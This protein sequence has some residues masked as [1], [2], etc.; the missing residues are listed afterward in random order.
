M[1]RTGSSYR[2]VLLS[3][4]AAC[5]V[6]GIVA[7]LISRPWIT[8]DGVQ[9]LALANSI[10]EGRYGYA[11]PTGFESD[12]LRPPGYPLLLALL[13]HGLRVPLVVV[14]AMQAAAYLASIYL[15]QRFLQQRKINPLPF[16]AIA[17]MYPFV[18]MY[19]ARTMAEGWTILAVT[20]VTV[21]LGNRRGSWSRSAAIGL[22]CGL[23]ALMRSDLLLLP[24]VPAAVIWWRELQAGKRVV[25]AAVQA[26]LPIILTAI[27]V[28]PY[29][30]WNFAHHGRASPVPLASATGTS[31]Y[32][33]YWQGKLPNADIHALYK[34]VVTKRVI[35]SGLASDLVEL[36]RQID[37]PL[38]TP[39]WNPA[40]YRSGW[41]QVAAAKL[42]LKAAVAR[43]RADPAP[44]FKHVAL[45][46][47]YLWNTSEYPPRI[48]TFLT[49]GLTLLSGSIT[50][51]GAFGALLVFRR[52]C[53]GV[54][55]AVVFIVLYPAA[56]HLWLHTEARYTA[57]VRPIFMMLAS[58]AILWIFRT[59]GELGANRPMGPR[60]STAIAA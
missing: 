5:F 26:T 59:L 22:I 6:Q 39:P 24:I 15:L 25:H 28:L 52:K 29:A 34:G 3:L 41:Q 37:A 53:G 38:L 23:A 11:T 56:F 48:P 17:A 20:G 2:T 8:E 45:N 51:L 30:M 57:S 9:Y 18:M 60:S 14:V 47:W 44:Y 42:S 7:I 50:L 35:E 1:N 4:W 13:V 19:V 36:N 10:A 43:I 54:P 21:L 46:S 12:V 32:L 16:L 31:L 58:L 33:S 49:W 55:R 27:V 40:D